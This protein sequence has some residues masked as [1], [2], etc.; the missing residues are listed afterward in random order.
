MQQKKT[1]MSYLI[2]GISILTINL[3]SCQH[4]IEYRL[5]TEFV[6]INESNSTITFTK[7]L[8]RGRRIEVSLEPQEKDTTLY[9]ASGGFENPNPNSCCQG[10]LHSVL[11]A[12]DRGNIR[13]G[14]DDKSCL[15]EA[16]TIIS[17]YKSE[18]IDKR[19]FRYTFVFTD[20]V[21]ANTLDCQ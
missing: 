4:Q 19:F 20:E 6:F 15:I 16:P 18:I 11:D 2:F 14:F 12:S 9:L 13:V 5:D 8:S 21:L 17:N 7:K 3:S 10:L 1:W